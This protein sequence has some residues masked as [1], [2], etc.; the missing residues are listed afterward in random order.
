VKAGV[1]STLRSAHVSLSRLRHSPISEGRRPIHPSLRPCLS[2]G[3]GCD[4][5]QSVKEPPRILQRIRRVLYSGSAAYSIADPPRVL[6]RI[7]RVLYSGSAAYSI[8]DP[9]CVLKRI[10][11]AIHSGSA[12]LTQRVLQGRFSG[13]SAPPKKKPFADVRTR[14]MPLPPRGPP[15]RAAADRNPTAVLCRRAH[16]RGR[17]GGRAGGSAPGLDRRTVWGG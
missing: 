14:K 2:R 7:R 4:T 17:A 11:R 1:R 13:S 10:R 3:V 5:R 16:A 6:Q 9:P 8:A 12:T 15:A